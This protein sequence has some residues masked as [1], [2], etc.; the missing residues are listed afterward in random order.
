[1]KGR[2]SEVNPKPV[3]YFF[4]EEDYLIEEAIEGIK[5]KILAKG[6]ESMNCQAFDAATDDPED[7]IAAAKTLPAFSSFRLVI[8]KGA[9]SM[10][11]AKAKEFLGYLKEPSPSTCLVFSAPAEAKKPD[12][13]SEFFKLLMAKAY[14]KEFR[15]L[16]E[17]E[18]VAWIKKYAATEG[19]DILDG[20]ALKLVNIAGARLRNIKEEM[21][22]IITFAGE[23]KT[24]EEGDVAACA[25]EVRDDTAFDLAS[26]IGKKD[27]GK[28]MTILER[29]DDEAVSIIG[30]IAW[31][32]RT[33]AKLK[34]LLTKRM[35]AAAIQ[36][37][38][39]L[40]GDRYNGYAAA[41]G[42]FSET[43]ILRAIVRLNKADLDIKS[44]R[45][46]DGAALTGLVM[47]LCAKSN[48]ARAGR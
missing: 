44:G 14:A 38:V 41:C 48:A 11:A 43:E 15:T 18:L 16:K 9:A 32:M 1:M 30:A 8:V 34:A 39:R 23:N 46:S 27:M 37:T 20:A 28:A 22:K 29:L 24:I 17:S 45:L 10:K 3:W 42:N 21:E 4:G 13:D 2:E 36:Q 5:K 33:L 6:F 7:I 40:W 26:A 12:K 35:P 31:Q 25:L 19:K 47:D